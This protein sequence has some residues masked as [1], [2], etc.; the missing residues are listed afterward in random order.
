M[1]G[2]EKTNSSYSIIM[3]GNSVSATGLRNVI[4]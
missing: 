4:L 2:S 1:L 3:L